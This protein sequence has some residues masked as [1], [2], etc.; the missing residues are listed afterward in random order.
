MEYLIGSVTT[1][2]AC[3]SV[4]YAIQKANKKVSRVRGFR[5]QSTL[6][7]LMAPVYAISAFFEAPPPLPKSQ[8]TEH[9]DK[10]TIRILFTEDKAY[11]IS[12]NCFYEAPIV[13]GEVDQD[14]KQPV[15]I[16]ALDNV[17]LEEMYFI[18]DKLTE[19]GSDEGNGTGI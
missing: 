17:Q 14:S 12:D 2:A 10:N 7:E 11:W 4:Y 16:M 5:T 1:L 19:G 13:D 8:S 18:V 3:F 15:D 6:Y 9:R